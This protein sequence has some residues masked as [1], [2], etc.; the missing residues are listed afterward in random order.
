MI[1]IYAIKNVINCKAYVGQTVQKLH[2]RRGGNRWPGYDGCIKLANAIKKHGPSAFHY[3]VIGR[4]NRQED[5][6]MLETMWINVFDSVRNG[7]NIHPGPFGGR[8]L[9]HS[10]EYID[11]LKR[12]RLGPGN[13]MFGRP[14][15]NRGKSPSDETRAKQSIAAHNRRKQ[16]VCIE[17]DCGKDAEAKNLC[18]AHYAAARHVAKI[19]A[20]GPLPPKPSMYAG[21][22]CAEA[23]CGK[24]A[25]SKGLCITH[26]KAAH[27]RAKRAR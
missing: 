15:G 16:T 7:Y 23:E 4:C 24:P 8:G 19:A 10:Q 11:R 5:A 9:K 1:T 12:E 14:A 18:K 27:H 20:R 22:S 13:P 6:D 17:P 2:E 25:R 21:V 26:Y 3:E